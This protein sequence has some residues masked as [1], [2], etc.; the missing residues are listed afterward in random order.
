MGAQARLGPRERGRS[1]SYG[2]A[3]STRGLYGAGGSTSTGIATAVGAFPPGGGHLHELGDCAL[4]APHPLV[5][6]HWWC[7]G[8]G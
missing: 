7:V 8:G 4:H 5:G 2:R 3:Y 6:R 1:R